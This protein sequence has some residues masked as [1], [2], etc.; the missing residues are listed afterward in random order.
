LLIQG[1][2][3]DESPAHRHHHASTTGDAVRPT[4]QLDPTI[5]DLRRLVAGT[6]PEQLTEPTPCA[7]WTVRDLV[8]HLVGGG[9]MFGAAFRGE[10]M[11]DPDAPMPD[12]LGDD[13]VAAFEAAVADFIDGADTPGAMERPVALPFATLPGE[14]ALQIASFDLMV[15]CW[16]LATST[17]QAYEPSAESAE[18]ALAVAQMII[19]PEARDGDTFAAEVPA[20]T[21]ATPLE[22]LVAFTG[23]LP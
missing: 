4:E 13:H 17:G 3:G 10:P 20:P 8:N 14:V 12:L 7:K 9:H 2:T 19:Q 18:G 6:R 16:D 15:H 1:R 5:T 22:R 11:G 21:G 23:R